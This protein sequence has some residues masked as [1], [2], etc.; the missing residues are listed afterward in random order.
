MK[1][2]NYCTATNRFFS[3]SIRIR[4]HLFLIFCRSVWLAEIAVS[5]KERDRIPLYIVK[6]AKVGRGGR[7]NASLCTIWT[8]Q[9]IFPKISLIWIIITTI[10]IIWI[11][12]T[13]Q[14]TAK[15]L[16]PKSMVASLNLWY[17]KSRQT[18]RVDSKRRYQPATKHLRQTSCTWPSEIFWTDSFFLNNNNTVTDET[19]DHPRSA[20]SWRILLSVCSTFPTHRTSCTTASVLPWTTWVW[21]TQS[22]YSTWYP[23]T[24]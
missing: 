18:S 21:V 1:T 17:R 12:R 6:W 5:N 14:V 16:F 13:P 8:L 24:M 9:I 3:C 15:Y 22:T 23:T 11:N 4:I 10:T 19:T 20:I 7:S 2:M